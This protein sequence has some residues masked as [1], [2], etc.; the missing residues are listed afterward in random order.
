MCN[1]VCNLILLEFVFFFYQKFALMKKVSTP[2]VCALLHI[3][4]KC[5]CIVCVFDSDCHGRSWHRLVT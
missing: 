2:Q 1:Y 3:W 4:E 5:V